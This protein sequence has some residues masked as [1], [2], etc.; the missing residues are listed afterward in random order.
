M[1]RTSD[2]LRFAIT[3]Y[4]MLWIFEDRSVNFLDANIVSR[5]L[6][7]HRTALELLEKTRWGDFYP[8]QTNES[9]PGTVPRYVN[10][11]G[12]REGDNLAWGD[13]GHFRDRCL[14]WSRS[15]IPPVGGKDLWDI[16]QGEPV[17]QNVSGIVR[18]SW[19]RRNA[20][21][22]RTWESY[23]L[24]DI[25]PSLGWSGAH[26]EWARN[27]TGHEGKMILNLE[28]KKTEL[29]YDEVP[30]DGF[31]KSGGKIRSVKAMLTI[32]D[33]AGSG[34][35]WDMRLHGVRWPKQGTILMTTSSEKFDGIFGLPHLSPSP[36]FFH[37]SKLLLNQ[38]IS[39]YLVEKGKDHFAD[40]TMPWGS[41]PE[42]NIDTLNPSPHCEYVL[43]AQVHPPD[44]DRLDMTSFNPQV[45]NMAEIIH[46]IEQELRFPIG[47]PVRGVPELQMSAVVWSPDCAFFLET[48]GPPHYAAADGQHLIGMKDE[49]IYYQAKVWLLIYAAVIFAQVYLLKQEMKESYTPSTIGRI[50][51]YT[52]SMLVMADGM[53]FAS[54]AA[55]TLSASTAFLP[56]LT[57]M[58]AAFVSMTIGGFFLGEI[59]KVQEPIHRR[60]RERGQTSNEV[61]PPRS[62]TLANDNPPADSLPRPVTAAPPRPNRPSSP[63][64][65]IPS[66]QDI[67]AEIAEVTANTAGG[68]AAVPSTG[69]TGAS[70]TDTPSP[71]FST[72]IGRF[73]LI[74]SGILLVAVASLS[75][76]PRVRSAFLNLI[77]LTYLSFW[78]PQIYRNVIRNCRR[79]LSWRFMIGQSILRLIPFAYLYLKDENVLFTTPDRMTFTIFAGWIWLQLWILAFQDF[80]GPRLLVPKAWT[81]DA[82]DYHP[83]LREDNLEDG[84]LPIGLV[85]EPGSPTVER[86]KDKD[87]FRSS[88][89]SSEDIKDKSKSSKSKSNIRVIDCAICREDLEVPV[90]RAGENDPTAGGVVGVF[91]RRMYMVT[92]CRHIFHSTCLEGWM[93]FRLQCPI[94]REE[95]PPL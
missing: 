88:S 35:S 23:N 44:R 90:M 52:T 14:E 20:S 27:M 28:D 30:G 22:S 76:Y 77:A 41:D 29:A 93:R 39:H 78:V 32:E 42:N 18:G 72:V 68:A 49:I 51:Y 91:T 53:L 25:M 62:G 3:L 65:I 73:I 74:S 67:D 58:F 16:G 31:A 26:S 6:D 48:K 75:W 92:P 66:D 94:C 60:E 86:E 13:L 69:V 43:Y 9:V 46:D 81:P 38:T 87:L 82:W 61:S 2:G 70:Q 7:H 45:E 34:I 21:T 33:T 95:L 55:W 71:S 80:L 54:A 56:F 4:I 89:N 37:S 15:A 63:P 5:R 64:I 79:A 85:P 84:G 40:F 10:L 8:P 50:S 17:W 36:D 83:V 24:T 57:L 59:H 47:A 12:F 19:V 11:T 1:S